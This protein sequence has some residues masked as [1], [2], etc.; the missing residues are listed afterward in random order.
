MATEK[1][2]HSLPGAVKTVDGRT[3]QEGYGEWPDCPLCGQ[4]VE[5]AL[6]S[7]HQNAHAASLRKG[8]KS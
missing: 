4:Q 1:A 7:E 2:A 6:F 3:T 5:P 8:E